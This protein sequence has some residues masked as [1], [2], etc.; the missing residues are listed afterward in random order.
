MKVSYKYKKPDILSV[1]KNVI[2]NQY[3]MTKI[4]V[5][6]K[7]NL[8]HLKTPIS[9]SMNWLKLQTACFPMMFIPNCEVTKQSIIIRGYEYSNKNKKQEIWNLLKAK[10]SWPISLDYVFMLGQY[11]CQPHSDYWGTGIAKRS[12]SKFITVVYCQVYQLL[13][14]LHAHS[15][16]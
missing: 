2:R 3:S 5:N 14:N 4:C 8:D 12:V 7:W 13:Y 10:H 9:T 6:K 16:G 11:L 1:Q 15:S